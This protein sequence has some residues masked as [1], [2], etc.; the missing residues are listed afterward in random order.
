VVGLC[1]AVGCATPESRY[2]ILSIFFD[3]VPLPESMRPPPP[4]EEDLVAEDTVPSEP[5]PPSI[6]WARHDPDCDECHSSATTKRP[7]ADPP[8]LCWECH[9]EKDFA[10]E[11]L[12]GPFA[13]GACLEC[14]D[15]HKSPNPTLLILAIPDLCGSCHDA[16]TFA[17]LEQHR[18]QEGDDCIGCHNPHAAP[19]E[20]MLPGNAAEARGSGERAV[21]AQSSAAD[22][23]DVAAP[24]RDPR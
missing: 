15:V 2:R 8:E 6:E 12:H 14:H 13:A 24:P 3:D 21:A 17:E 7:S 16:T 22:G 18:S 1:L 20:F 11:V 23:A 10:D 9:D 5:R 19:R 4:P